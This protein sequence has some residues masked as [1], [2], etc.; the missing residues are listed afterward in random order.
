MLGVWIVGFTVLAIFFPSSLES[1]KPDPPQ[2]TPSPAPAPSPP[3]PSQPA[4]DH[5]GA[6]GGFKAAMA[7]V[8]AIWF[9]GV[10][11]PGWVNL[12]YP[13]WV[14]PASQW[15]AVALSLLA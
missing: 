5:F 6:S 12:G 9:L 2:S 3:S 14:R 15:T 8:A 7:T 11:V 1:R 13:A 4:T 10:T